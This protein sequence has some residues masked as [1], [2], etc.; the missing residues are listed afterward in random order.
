MK[1]LLL[2]YFPAGSPGG[3]DCH[4]IILNLY[5]FWMIRRKK[6]GLLWILIFSRAI[7]LSG[8]VGSNTPGWRGGIFTSSYTPPHFAIFLSHHI[9][10]TSYRR[11]HWSG[12]PL[13][14][15]FY[16]PLLIS[17]TLPLYLLTLIPLSSN[18]FSFPLA[19]SPLSI[20]RHTSDVVPPPA[21]FSLNLLLTRGLLENQS[22]QQF[23]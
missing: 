3:S 15:W 13:V 6:T 23:H 1:L 19:T 11:A 8:G 10:P 2:D 5:L 17:Q 21:P 7:F 16:L 20:A 12:G 18:S 22:A 9:S 4:R 14:S